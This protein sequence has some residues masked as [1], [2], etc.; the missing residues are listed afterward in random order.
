MGKSGL[1]AVMVRTSGEHT[2]RFTIS[3]RVKLPLTSNS[4][5][6]AVSSGREVA[7]VAALLWLPLEDL[8]LLGGVVFVGSEPAL[9]ACCCCWMGWE[10][11]HP[12]I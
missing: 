9:S 3:S 12:M 8:W 2:V 5:S 10:V 7:V 1:P 6:L 4:G 11:V